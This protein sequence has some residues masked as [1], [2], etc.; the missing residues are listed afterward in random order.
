[1]NAMKYDF[2]KLDALLRR[3]AAESVPS[4]ACAFVKDG[5][6]LYEGYYG[7]ADLEA[8]APVT[9]ASLYRQASMTKLVTYTILMMLMEQ[10]KC[11][12]DQPLSDFYPAWADKTKFV[13]C[14]DGYAIVPL[15]KTI[16]LG[17]CTAMM[18]GMPYCFGPAPSDTKDPVLKAMSQAMQPVWAKGHYRVQEAIAAMAQVPVAFEPGTDWMYGFGSE[19]VGGVVE[20]ITGMPLYQAMRRYIFMPLDMRDTD[21]LFHD[22]FE[23][24]LVGM[25]T[26]QNGQFIRMPADIDRGQRPGE[27][28]EEGRP[29]LMTNVRDFSKLMQLWAHDGVYK[30]VRLLKPETMRF[31]R[32]NLLSGDVLSQYQ[33]GPDGY[34]AGYG[35]GYGVRTLL[36]PREG[37]GNVGSYGWTGG[38]GS[39]CEADPVEHASIV[40]MHNMIPNREQEHHLPVR[41]AAYGAL[42]GN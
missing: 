37:C 33:G 40:Y 35:Y 12:M 8:K 22:D 14:E 34:N 29:S 1:M 41:A 3:F 25:Y 4:C 42:R 10:G 13:P 17:D 11:R 16:T 15:E 28:N 2:S 5:E 6:L 9:P 18:C 36:A 39:W 20:L 19:I 27:E 38:Y 32:Q 31:M 7:Y 26:V 23:Q 21:T 24:R 30:G